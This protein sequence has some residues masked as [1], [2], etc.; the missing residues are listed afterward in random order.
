MKK[1][2]FAMAIGCSLMA[3]Q[4]CSKCGQCVVTT[5]QGTLTNKDTG[6]VYCGDNNNESGSYYK[7]AKLSCEQTEVRYKEENPGS[8]VSVSG[9][10]QD[11]K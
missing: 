8:T 5:S 6:S 9:A 7:A 3:F 1:L 11:A 2:F 10:W 4:S